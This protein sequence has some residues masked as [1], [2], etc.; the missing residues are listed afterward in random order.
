MGSGLLSGFNFIRPEV[1]L[2]A[3][4]YRDALI[5][6]IVSVFGLGW[7]VSAIGFMQMLGMAVTLAGA[8]LVFAGI[9]RGRFQTSD[10]GP[11]YVSIDEG[12]V[13]YF[14]PMTGG[15][16]HIDDLVQVDLVPPVAKAASGQ[17]LLLPRYGDPL[18]IPVNAVGAERLFD[19]FAKLRGIRTG[20]MLDVLA[21]PP[22][23]QVVIW[24]VDKA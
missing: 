13:T 14:G 23:H 20:H 1:R 12:Q 5:G 21:A 4:R 24:A 3:W 10:A 7:A 22:S 18:A 19:V 11:G 8:L 15:T 17:W 6:A 16:V 2:A 9:Q